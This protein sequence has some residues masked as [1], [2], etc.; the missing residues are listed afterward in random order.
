MSE[1]PTDSQPDNDIYT[2]L[3]ILATVIVAGAVVFL[4]MR[5]QTLFGSWNPFSGA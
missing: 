2:V 3:V 4:V 1:R 5:S